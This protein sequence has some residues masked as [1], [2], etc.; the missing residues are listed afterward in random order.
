MRIEKLP[1]LETKI[2]LNSISITTNQDA[3]RK[4]F[5]V[6]LLEICWTEKEL[7][8]LLSKLADSVASEELADALLDDLSMSFN[9]LDRLEDILLSMDEAAKFKACDTMVQLIAEAEK[10]ISSGTPGVVQDAAIF[11]LVKRIR[12]SQI[13]S[14]GIICSFLKNMEQFEELVIMEVSLDE[15]RSAYRNLLQSASTLL[16]G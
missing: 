12:Y 13:A 11:S 1:H 5:R 3:L 16:N 10:I 7:T 4:L 8:L 6:E 9:H 2:P 15:E 14:Y